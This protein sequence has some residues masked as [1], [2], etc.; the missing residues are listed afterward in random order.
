MRYIIGIFLLL[1]VA[2]I[3]YEENPHYSAAAA[4][5][6]AVALL[7]VWLYPKIKA[8][9]SCGRNAQTA[10]LVK[11]WIILPFVIILTCYWIEDQ[12]IA[13]AL[14]VLSILLCLLWFV[15]YFKMREFVE[16]EMTKVRKVETK[17]A[18]P[19]PAESSAIKESQKNIE[20]PKE[21]LSKHPD[22]PISQA[23]ASKPKEIK[24][25]YYDVKGVFAHE[26][27][28]FHN[29]MFYNEDFDLTKSKIIKL[30]ECTDTVYKWIPKT[31]VAELVPEPENK[32]DPNSIKVVVAGVVVGYIPK[33]SCLEVHSLL[34]N[35]AIEK[36]FCHITGGICK[37]VIEEDYDYEK[38][39]YIYAVEIEKE[40]LSARLSLKI[41]N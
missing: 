7:V 3:R 16:A 36:A 26:D 11:F 9:K 34:S 27:A 31:G 19:A 10:A 29:L 13:L 32:Y 1:M 25:L 15:I 18:K 28:I 20:K 4:A 21:S 40:E 30:C 23:P 2:G 24:F 41:S 39:Q 17:T 8:L 6:G 22:P 5:I 12:R 37:R 35:G 33:E 38:D 14:L